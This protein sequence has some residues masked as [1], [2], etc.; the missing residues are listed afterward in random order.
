VNGNP[1]WEDWG[2]DGR[3]LDDKDQSCGM[4]NTTVDKKTM[5]REGRVELEERTLEGRERRDKGI[6]YGAM[7]RLIQRLEN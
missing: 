4:V 1:G 3:A 5:T 6:E 7:T 2:P